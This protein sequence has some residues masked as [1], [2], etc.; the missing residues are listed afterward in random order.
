M[1]YIFD[2]DFLIFR[3]IILENRKLNTISLIDGEPVSFLLYNYLFIHL[4]I[5]ILNFFAVN[6]TYRNV[7]NK[8]GPVNLFL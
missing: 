1:L 6:H 5:Y 8:N 2:Q 7:Y 4:F 3:K